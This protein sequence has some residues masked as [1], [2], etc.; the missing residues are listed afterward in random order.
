MDRLPDNTEFKPDFGPGDF[1]QALDVGP[2]TRELTAIAA[3]PRA[4]SPALV[5]L[6]R[7]WLAVL[8]RI[9]RHAAL[10]HIT[11]KLEQELHLPA[12]ALRSRSRDQRTCFA[13]HLAIYLCRETTD[14]PL[15]S[16]AEY[17]RRNHSTTL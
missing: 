3:Q 12:G 8:I 9:Q 16:I 11:R 6:A 14:A 4:S 10:A 15:R 1:S 2:L 5:G 17:F 7:Q 13:R